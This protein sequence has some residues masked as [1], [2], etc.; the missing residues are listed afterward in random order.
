MAKLGAAFDSGK[1]E[2]MGNFDPIPAGKY[3][4]KI[5]ESDILD[6]KKKNGKY[7]QF[8]FEIIQGEFKGRLIWAR[9][10]IINPS[11]VAVEIAQKELAT[12][13]RAVGKAVVQD[14][15]ELH[16]IPLLLTVKLTPAKGDYPAGNAT[17]GYASLSGGSSAGP[18]ASG[19]DASDE[20]PWGDEDEDAG[21]A[22]NGDP[23]MEV[24]DDDIPF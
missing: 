10:N 23:D 8:K 2:D 16:G 17:A 24:I 3:P 21:S 9:L 15:Q 22:E 14:T 12:I 5:I 18:G 11:S 13:C 20:V 7:I 1:H 19:T 4:A 6:T